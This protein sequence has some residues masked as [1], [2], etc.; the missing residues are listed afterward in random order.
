MAELYDA[1]QV[2]WCE[3][4]DEER[5]IASEVEDEASDDLPAV[6]TTFSG[7]RPPATKSTKHLQTGELA[8]VE[9]ALARLKDWLTMRPPQ[10]VV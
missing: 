3:F 7:S 4:T 10:D 6:M 9:G 8:K 2:I 5:K 1:S